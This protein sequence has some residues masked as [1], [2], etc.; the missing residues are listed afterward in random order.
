MRLVHDLLHECADVKLSECLEKEKYRIPLPDQLASEHGPEGDKAH[1]GPAAG[2]GAMLR[3][4]AAALL[5]GTIVFSLLAYFRID[6]APQWVSRFIARL[7]GAHPD[8]VSSSSSDGGL[9]KLIQYKM[10]QLLSS[11]PS[12]KASDGPRYC[13]T[14]ST[15]S[16]HSYDYCSHAWP[17]VPCSLLYSN[18][19]YNKLWP[20]FSHLME[21]IPNILT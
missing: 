11:A 20:V 19:I 16:N 4:I 6:E 2:G 14:Q 8:Q 3:V 18:E 12:F 10:D 13:M 5:L 7:L 21:S 1:D 15:C 17:H 9:S